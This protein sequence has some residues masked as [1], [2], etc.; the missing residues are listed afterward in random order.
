M[1]EAKK[2]RLLLNQKKTTKLHL[3]RQLKSQS[4]IWRLKKLHNSVKNQS[5]M[6]LDLKLLVCVSLA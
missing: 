3:E 2:K 1:T 5:Q 6:S 4:K